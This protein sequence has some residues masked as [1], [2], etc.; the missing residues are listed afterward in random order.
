MHKGICEAGIAE[1]RVL[2]EDGI[3]NGAIQSPGVDVAVATRIVAA[4]VGPGRTDI[5]L[6]EL[7]A[8]L[9]EVLAS[10]S[11]RKQL[12]PQRRKRLARQAVQFIRRGVGHEPRVNPNKEPA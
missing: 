2:L 12:G 5:V 1:I 11:L 6:E 8:E 9:H 7:G 4:I 3:K 10:D